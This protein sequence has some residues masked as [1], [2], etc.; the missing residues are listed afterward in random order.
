VM[1]Q[2]KNGRNMMPREPARQESY[3]AA[4]PRNAYVK[5]LMLSY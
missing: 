2:A 4:E 1:H 3:Q 5:Y